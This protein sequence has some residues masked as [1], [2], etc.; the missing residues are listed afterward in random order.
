M[1]IK[2]IWSTGTDAK[3]QEYDAHKAVLSMRSKFFENAFTGKFKEASS[4]VIELHDDDPDHFKLALQFMYS[5]T[6][7]HSAIQQ[8]ITEKDP[9]ARVMDAVGVAIVGDK[10]QI[11]G[12]LESA[13]TELR[14]TMVKMSS[15]D[16]VGFEKAMLQVVELYYGGCARASTPVG[17]ALVDMIMAHPKDR[18]FLEK[19][20][21]NDLVKVCVAFGADLT[22]HQLE[23]GTLRGLRM[24]KCC[25]LE[26]GIPYGRTHFYCI[27]CAQQRKVVVNL[28]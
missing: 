3:V 16:V 5:V 17:K 24:V 26:F 21:V 2:Q 15:D 10:Y 27:S 19:P 12:L 14:D 1:K 20:E 4:N 25:N 8:L 18:K 7:D 6:Y 28:A 9:S 23:Q 13:E 22:L 11:E